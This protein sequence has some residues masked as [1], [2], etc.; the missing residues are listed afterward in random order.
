MSD[1][2][3]GRAVLHERPASRRCRRPTSTA[4]RRARGAAG[5]TRRSGRPAASWFWALSASATSTTVRPAAVSF[6]RIEHDLDL[7]RVARE[8][9]DAAGARHARER[10]P[11]DVERVV[12][13]LGRRQ[14]AGQA[15]D[16]H[17]K[18][19]RRQALD[20]QLGVGRQLAAD[21]RDAVLHLLQRDDHVGRRVEL[22]GDLGR[23]ADAAST[24]RGGCPAPPSP[25]ARSAA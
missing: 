20:R 11:H 15:E 12:V 25:P 2:A 19:R 24:A 14:V 9:L 3:D 22:R 17:G 4:P 6:D 16:E 13:Q 23:A 5:R 1:D 7:A 10:R 8:H 18:H 21:L